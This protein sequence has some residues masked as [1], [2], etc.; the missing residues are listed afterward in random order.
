MCEYIFNCPSGWVHATRSFSVCG[1][2]AMVVTIGRCCVKAGRLVARGR[3]RK[4][5]TL[6]AMRRVWRGIANDLGMGHEN[7]G[8]VALAREGWTNGQLS[9]A[10]ETRLYTVRTLPGFSEALG[11]PPFD[12]VMHMLYLSW[13]TRHMSSSIGDENNGRER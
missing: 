2:S 12:F 8:R 1:K 4:I 13:P 6:H 10:R 5:S 9:W 11:S 3:S 7:V